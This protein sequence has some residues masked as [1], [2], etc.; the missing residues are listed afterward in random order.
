MFADYLT[1]KVVLSRGRDPG[2]RIGS[3]I[4][5]GIIYLVFIVFT[6]PHLFT[7]MRDSANSFNSVRVVRRICLKLGSAYTNERL[8][9]LT[10]ET[11]HA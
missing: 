7:T 9:T 11:A 6:L 4:V 3:K 1:L 2:G 10:I 5:D 8:R